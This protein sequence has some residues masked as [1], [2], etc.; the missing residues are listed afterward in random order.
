MFRRILLIGR[1]GIVRDSCGDRMGK[2]KVRRA[3]GRLRLFA[4]IEAFFSWVN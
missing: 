3:I 1:I 2:G 4:P